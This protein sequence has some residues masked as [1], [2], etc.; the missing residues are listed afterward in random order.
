MCVSNRTTLHNAAIVCLN[1]QYHNY[2][3]RHL[4][5]RELLS[6]MS[7]IFNWLI[8]QFR[9]ILD[10]RHQQNTMNTLSLHQQSRWT[11]AHMWHNSS[12]L[13]DTVLHYTCLSLRL[14]VWKACLIRLIGSKAVLWWRSF[15]TSSWLRSN[16]SWQDRWGGGRGLT[17]VM[18]CTCFR[19]LGIQDSQQCA[20]HSENL[21]Q[22]KRV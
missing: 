5:E 6:V 15:T 18:A 17:G 11:D 10:W 7:T 14:C 8:Y 20:V 19:K 9:T 13:T 3:A 4:Y 22:E 12:Y 1:L 21:K 16:H 2:L